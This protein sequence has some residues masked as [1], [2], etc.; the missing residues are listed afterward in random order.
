M[1]LVIER[2]AC[3]DGG[4]CAAYIDNLPAMRMVR[5]PAGIR[6]DP[7]GGHWGFL[8]DIAWGIGL[9]AARKPP[10][11]RQ[12]L[13]L[14]VGWNSELGD[15]SSSRPHVRAV[16][17]ALRF[18]RC[19]GAL[20][21][22]AAG[23]TRGHRRPPEG[24]LVPGAWQTLPAPTEQECLDDFGVVTEAPL[25]GP[26]VYAVS[27]VDAYDRFLSIT[28][29][30]ARAPLAAPG[31]QVF[32]TDPNPP[33]GPPPVGPQTG[34]SGATAA[35]SALAAIAW[36]YYPELRPDQ[37]M[38][39]VA[40]AAVELPAAADFCFGAGACAPVRRL[41]ACGLIQ[42]ACQ[43]GRCSDA[44]AC[45]PD[46]PRGP[47]LPD[48]P[49]QGDEEDAPE[50]VANRR[51]LPLGFP[52]PPEDPCGSTCGLGEVTNLR[53]ARGGGAAGAPLQLRL[54]INPNLSRYKFTAYRLW[55]RDDAT[56]ER[57]WLKIDLQHRLPHHQPG[58][59]VLVL[60][61]DPAAEGVKGQ[62]HAA[63]VDFVYRDYLL[64]GTPID[65]LTGTPISVPPVAPGDG[66]PL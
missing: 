26:L 8:G 36:R 37:I 13:N 12:I 65:R 34:T 9:A 17:D 5:T 40:A 59:T 64:D 51:M 44:P 58:G 61:L 25:Q 39:K 32:V 49:T 48:P 62:I 53:A 19:R 2:V 33:V 35:A 21:I 42:A 31:L 27:A 41:S 56:P 1:G 54:P 55:I 66:E 50:T 30:G 57:G 43:D 11:R 45:Q 28:P 20:L 3:P 63:Q 14:S 18:A 46:Q 7:D 6:R 60:D 15:L 23:N 16:H 47:A 10:G 29:P 38:E 24:P 52:Q 22:A 4:T